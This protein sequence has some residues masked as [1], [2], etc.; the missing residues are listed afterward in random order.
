MKTSTIL[1]TVVLFLALSTALIVDTLGQGPPPW[2]PAHG[3]RAKTRQIYFPAYNFYFDMHRNSYIYFSGGSWLVSTSLPVMYAGVDLRNVSQVQLSL[4]T[5]TPQQYN[6]SH[7][8]KYKGNAGGPKKDNGNGGGQMKKA[9]GNGGGGHKE[10]N[11]NGGGGGH[12]GGGG[13]GGGGGKKK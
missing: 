10:S 2:A 1:R 7:V 3:Y 6:T 9:P 13:H 8:A 11:G 12:K 4:N 5:N